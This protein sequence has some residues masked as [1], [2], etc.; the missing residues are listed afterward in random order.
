MK[1]M[2]IHVLLVATGLLAGCSTTNTAT[3]TSAPTSTIRSYNGTASVGDFLT[4]TID[5]T[6]KTITYDNLTNGETGTAT[7]TVNTNGSYTVTDPQGNLLSAYEVPGSMMVV[8]AANAGPNRDSNALITA[9]ENAP[10]SISTVAGKSYNYMQFRTKDGGVEIG[11][12]SIDALGGI[13]PNSYDP[14]SM[15]WSGGTVFNSSQFPASSITEAANG[16]YFTIHEQDSSADVVFGTVGGLWAVDTANG[17]IIGLQ[18]AATKD[19]NPANAGTYNAVYYRK[20]N[21]QTQNNVETGTVIQGL[22]TI[23]IDTAGNITVVDDTGNTLASG[24]LVPVADQT[25]LYDHTANTL[26]D[27]CY[28]LFVIRTVTAT[29]HQEVF[30]AFQGNAVLYESFKTSLPVPSDGSGTYNYSYGVGTL[31]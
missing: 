23:T 27:P 2:K 8:E 11:T 3:T 14:G 21:A 30:V 6:A 29:S 12:V 7:Y 28:G 1:L 22:A 15:M 31:Q 17:A 19:F 5:P 13:S 10:I 25:W 4:I 18:K 16:D 24:Q 9:V 26:S 20:K